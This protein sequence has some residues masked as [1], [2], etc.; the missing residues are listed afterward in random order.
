MENVIKKKEKNNEDKVKQE[1]QG[2]SKNWEFDK[3]RP[4]AKSLVS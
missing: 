4:G 2:Q 3:E 1:G